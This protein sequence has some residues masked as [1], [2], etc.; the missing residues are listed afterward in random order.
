[1]CWGQVGGCWG[2]GGWGGGSQSIV[3]KELKIVE[4]SKK[5]WGGGAW[6]GGGVG[7]SG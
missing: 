3:N 5:I 1:M 4:N 2:G 7:G 6:S